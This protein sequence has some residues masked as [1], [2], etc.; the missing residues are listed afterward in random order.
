MNVIF[1]QKFDLRKIRNKTKIRYTCKK[2]DI[3]NKY[4]KSS[5]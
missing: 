3:H 4:K 5:F 1:T 2:F